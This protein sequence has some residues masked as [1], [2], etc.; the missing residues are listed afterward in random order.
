MMFLTMGVGAFLRKKGQINQE[1][2]QLLTSLVVNLLLP[3]NIIMAF[4]MELSKEVLEQSA[5]IIF[6]SCVIQFGSV[7]LAGILYKKY[8]ND[9]KQVLKYA[10]ICSNAGFLGNPVAEGI[11]GPL[12]LLYASVYLIPQ[13]I[14]MWSVGVTYFTKAPDKKTLLKK[15]IT[16]PCIV[17]VI[18]GTVLMLTQ[19]KMPIFLESTIDGMGR[20]TTAFTMMLIGV[21]LAEADLKS[22]VTKTTCYY[23]VLRLIGIPLLVFLGCKYT[24]VPEL[25]GGLSVILAGM[26]AGTTTAILAIQYKANEEFATKCVVLSTLLSMVSIPMWCMVILRFYS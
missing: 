14:I 22:I 26:P 19:W 2:K 3:C 13:R 24:G 5:L 15:V 16:H 12:G 7:V 11:Y 8:S 1:G 23:T 17:A 10:T 21:I 9:Q 20:C 25:I 6:V 4:Y 18:L